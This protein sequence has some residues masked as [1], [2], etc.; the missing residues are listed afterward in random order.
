MLVIRNTAGGGVV[1][2]AG[3]GRLLADV[4]EEQFSCN[5]R[6][7]CWPMRARSWES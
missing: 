6:R 7:R 5:C 3:V 1:S 2:L 4:L